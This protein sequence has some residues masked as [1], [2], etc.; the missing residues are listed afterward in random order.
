[1]YHQRQHREVMEQ[2]A[3]EEKAGELQGEYPTQRRR[4][5]KAANQRQVERVAS[6]HQVGKAARKPTQMRTYT[7]TRASST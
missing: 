7:R 4:A 2:A 1:M 5:V 3:G 6:P